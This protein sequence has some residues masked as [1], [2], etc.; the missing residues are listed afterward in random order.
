MYKKKG[1]KIFIVPALA[2]LISAEGQLGVLMRFT[3]ALA[4]FHWTVKE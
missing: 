1:K 2:F 3:S 4:L